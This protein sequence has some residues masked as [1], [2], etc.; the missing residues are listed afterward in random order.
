[1]RHSST[2]RKNDM[3]PIRTKSYRDVCVTALLMLASLFMS[4]APAAD[5]AANFGGQTY[6]NFYAQRS[7]TDSA[8]NVYVA[9]HSHDDPIVIGDIRVTRIGGGDYLI[10][11]FDPTGTLVWVKNFGGNGAFST[12]QELTVDAA[13][14]VYVGGYFSSS[15]QTFPALTKL[16]FEDAFVQKLGKDGNTIWARNFGGPQASAYCTSIAIDAASIVYVSG[17]FRGANLTSPA[18]TKLGTN[19]AFAFKLDSA[20]KT[21]WTKSFGGIEAA[22]YVSHIA[23]DPALNVYLVGSF[24]AANLTMPKLTK[25]GLIDAF[26]LKLDSI[27]EML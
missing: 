1:M 17:Q 24:D 16:G 5:F 21:V 22:T 13:E 25:F 2:K 14:N 4:H 7:T 23:I 19:D 6:L 27:G 11:K 3:Q 20:G 9:G 15:D 12:I 26:V 18:L 10:L 8:G